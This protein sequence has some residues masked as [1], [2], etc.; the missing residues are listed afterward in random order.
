MGQVPGLGAHDEKRAP[1]RFRSPG[2]MAYCYSWLFSRFSMRGGRSR[3]DT[4]LSQCAPSGSLFAGAHILQKIRPI[5]DLRKDHAT[6]FSGGRLCLKANPQVFYFTQRKVTHHIPVL[7]VKR[8]MEAK[9]PVHPGHA[10]I[11]SV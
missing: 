7:A 10:Q 5:N 1:E 3:D 11:D 8:V 2:R 4:A 6:T 9:N